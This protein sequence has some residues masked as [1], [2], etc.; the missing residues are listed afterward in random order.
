M[1][2][3]ILVISTLILCLSLSACGRK[4]DAKNLEIYKHNGT[5]YVLKYCGSDL[6][7]GSLYITIEDEK[8]VNFYTVSKSTYKL[9][10]FYL[11]IGSY[12]VYL[13][14]SV[15]GDK[16]TFTLPTPLSLIASVDDD[17][18]ETANTNSIKFYVKFIDTNTVVTTATEE[19]TTEDATTTETETTDGSTTTTETTTTTEKLLSDS[20][21][22]LSTTP[23]DLVEFI[24]NKEIETTTTS[25]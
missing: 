18:I 1:K 8:L 11:V 2:K 24:R 12:S 23:E 7:F 17:G 15:D 4:N 5:T 20:Y 6:D 16:T 19:T 3:I 25:E 21:I 10:K 13:E 22:S 9:S 14:T